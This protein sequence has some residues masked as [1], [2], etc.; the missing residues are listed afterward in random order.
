[1]YILFLFFYFVDFLLRV[2]IFLIIDRVILIFW[3]KNS[4]IN[5]I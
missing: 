2:I 1:M 5:E 4:L 3:K